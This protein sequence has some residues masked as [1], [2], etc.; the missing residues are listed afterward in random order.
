MKFV[1]L[2]EVARVFNG[3]SINEKVKAQNFT[4]LVEGIPYIA[5]KDVSFSFEVNYENGT[6][7]PAERSIEFKLAKAGNVLICAEGG[8]AGRKIAILD[9]DVHFGNKLFCF[10]TTEDLNSR[11]LFYYL[12]APYFQNLFKESITGLIGGVSLEKVRN[13]PIALPKLEKQR[14]FV[15]AIDYAFNE[16]T[17]LKENL[18][19]RKAQI[20]VLMRSATT[21][22]YLRTLGVN[23]REIKLGEVSDFEGGSQPAKS[24]FVYKELDGYV[25]FI[26][27]RDFGSDKN[28]TYIP[29]SS[30]NRLCDE[31][32][33]L[34]GRYGASVGKIL[35]GLSGAYN[36]ALM[37]VIP[38]KN[39]IEKDYL[40]YYLLSDLFQDNLAKVSD[41][42]AQNGFSKEDIFSFVLHLPSL[43]EQRQVVS[44]LSE[45]RREVESLK[46]K[47]E[48]SESLL[49][50]LSSS[51]LNRLFSQ[52]SEAA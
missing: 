4:N 49:A 36:V 34:I 37:K 11:F 13:L 10:E 45:I 7:I 22:P 50:S 48:R 21:T 46:F 12:Q 31:S 30:K 26:Q 15:H 41:R 6:S 14:E 23:C 27:I 18:E 5:T 42:S 47:L 28:L 24:N 39:I 51:L 8:S 9:R 38:K 25:R 40:Y 17:S 44:R 3:N 32:D 43:D 2:G 35:T 20:E 52:N 16:I 29:I 1:K 19:R 33:I